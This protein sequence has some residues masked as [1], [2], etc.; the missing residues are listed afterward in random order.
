MHGRPL[1]L[2]LAAGAAAAPLL[3]ACHPAP[4]GTE[5]PLSSAATLVVDNRGFTD[6]TIYVLRGGTQRIRL[7][8]AIGSSTQRFTI[9]ADIIAGSTMLRFVADPIGGRRSPVSDE[10]A[11]RAGD[12][13]TLTIPPS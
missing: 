7:G 5:A 12:T 11:V 9:P 4:P 10:I 3:T 1:A 6:M 8:L 13:V 2:L